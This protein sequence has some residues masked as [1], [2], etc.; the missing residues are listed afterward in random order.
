MNK[1]NKGFTLIELLVVIAIISL[2]ASVIFAS[3]SSA[4]GGAQDAKI[5]T[6]RTQS[7]TA[8]DGFSAEKGGY[9]NDGDS[10]KTIYCVGGTDCILGNVPQSNQLTSSDLSLPNYTNMPEVKSANG[11]IIAK[12]IMYVDCGIP[13][14]EVC[15]EGSGAKIITATNRRGLSAYLPGT[16]KTENDDHS[17]DPNFYDE[18]NYPYAFIEGDEG[19]SGPSDEVNTYGWTHQPGFYYCSSSI[20]GSDRTPYYQGKGLCHTGYGPEGYGN[21]CMYSADI[22][23]LSRSDYPYEFSTNTGEC[24][25]GDGQTYL[26]WDMN[27]TGSF[28]GF[29]YFTPPYYCQTSQFTH[30]TTNTFPDD[31]TTNTNWELEYL[32]SHIFGKGPSGV[33]WY[34]K[35]ASPYY[36]DTN[37]PYALLVSIGTEKCHKTNGITSYGWYSDHSN[38]FYYC[39]NDLSLSYDGSDTSFIDWGNPSSWRNPNNWADWLP[40]RVWGVGPDGEGWYAL[41]D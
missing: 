39:S 1:K 22:I 5:D 28:G 21:Y 25:A 31:F 36:D 3:I 27:G 26:G 10:T 7:Q 4:K 40:D 17:D 35:T 15:P 29:T 13:D 9:P 2:L 6:S 38:D 16:W 24:T 14:V 12:G 37:Y 20:F 23:S 11:I 8:L 18:T 32:P 33:G 41:G 34:G 19:C 30:Y